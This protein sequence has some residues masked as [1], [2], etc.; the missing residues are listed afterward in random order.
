M[1]DAAVALGFTN[2]VDYEAEWN[3]DTLNGLL[4]KYD[5]SKEDICP[6]PV[7]QTIRQLLGVIL[8]HFSR[9]SGCGQFVENDAALEE[10]L[11][12]FHCR[13]TLGGTAVRAALVLER[14]GLGSV[15]HLVST[16][17]VTRQLLPPAV[18]SYCLSTKDTL[19]PHLSIQFPKGARLLAAGEEWVSPRSNRVIFTND[20]TN[21]DLPL[22]PAFFE[23]ARN[24]SVLV[25][26]SFDIIQDRQVLMERLAEVKSYLECC[27]HDGWTF[28]EDANFTNRQF[29]ALICQELLPYIDFYSLNEDEFSARCNRHVNFE[30]SQ[31][32]LL[33]LQEVHR[34]IPVRC[35]IL[36]TQHWALAY[37]ELAET[38]RNA[39]ENGI[40]AATTRYRLGD[41][42]TLN[43]LAQTRCSAKY[44]QGIQMAAG[45][46]GRSTVPLVVQPGY[47]AETDSPTTIGLGD[48]FVGGF[49][50][51]LY[52]QKK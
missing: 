29:P 5:L 21:A 41:D 26:S 10:L 37:G 7:I 6:W 47:F 14:L 4:K 27:P 52:L 15:V 50:A 35:L 48:S 23:A 16:N 28:Y 45:L 17:Q 13:L 12:G 40:A 8:W 20:R 25:L 9:G 44:Q 39:L 42:W 2:T 22:V 1:I 51:A 18:Q 24:C 19:Y 49:A 34:Q 32:V 33:A 36:H 30:D 31:D 38:A 11:S 46:A 43:D 3:A